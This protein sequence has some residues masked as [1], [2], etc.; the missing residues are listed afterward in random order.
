LQGLIKICAAF[1]AFLKILAAVKRHHACFATSRTWASL[2][3][4]APVLIRELLANH[5][6]EEF[7]APSDTAIFFGSTSE[8]TS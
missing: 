1:A 3:L 7:D 8:T 5:E 4:Q 2:N 6:L